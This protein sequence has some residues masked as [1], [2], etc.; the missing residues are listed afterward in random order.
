MS[1]ESQLELIDARELGSRLQ[2][3]RKEARKTQDEVATFL[4]VARTTVTA[5][6]KGERRV[7]PSELVKL[8]SFYSQRLSDLL[9]REASAAPLALQL[10]AVA[11]ADESVEQLLE[12]HAWN[13]QHLCEDYA[14]LE[15]IC[16]S[17]MVRHH[18]RERALGSVAS[19][20]AAE[21]LAVAE[22]NRLGL[23]DGPV[24]NLRDTLEQEVG[25]RIFYIAM[26]SDIAGMFA[27]DEHLG[28]CIAINQQ[29]R[30]VRRRLSLAHEYAH[31]LTSR[32][33]ASV[34][35]AKRYQRLPEGERFANAFAPAFLM[36]AVGISRRFNEMK[37]VSKGKFTYANL[38][39]LAH[40][41][42]VSVES[43]V[44]RL[45]QLR[46]VPRGTWEKIKESGF[47]PQEG[48]AVL[49]LVEKETAAD[50]LPTRYLMLAVQGYREGLLTEGQLAR[51]LRVDILEARRVL[52]ES[53]GSVGSTS[54]PLLGDGAIDRP[55]VGKAGA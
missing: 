44:R 32:R 17:P 37:S 40:Y 6:E 41:F 5:M 31:F 36:P 25:L 38:L 26:P 48:K 21:D 30:E 18:P 53:F 54:A 33:Q 49:K 23:G 39:G 12:P 14:E 50:L 16:K 27:F 4:D 45:E 15:R 42:A 2:A 10:R 3:A 28:G 55:E 47:R 46:L 22:R 7:R 20:H 24:A 19:I 13:L 8:A 35:F 9:R 43:L 29:H 34:D 11:T 52:E 1:G 51:W